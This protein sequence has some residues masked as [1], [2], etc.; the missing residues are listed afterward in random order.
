MSTHADP[1]RPRRSRP[2]FPLLRGGGRPDEPTSEGATPPTPGAGGWVHLTK[3][4]DAPG[5]PGRVQGDDELGRLCEERAS[6]TSKADLE[7]FTTQL[8]REGPLKEYSGALGAVS[9]YVRSIL[10]AAAKVDFEVV[11]VVPVLR[12][13]LDEL[14]DAVVVAQ[15]ALETLA[16]RWGVEEDDPPSSTSTETP[17]SHPGSATEHPEENL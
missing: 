16:R 11:E 17:E 15:G 9:D 6:R 14:A 13:R 8:T 2:R 10:H 4:P 5:A 7:R 12:R 1:R 3:T